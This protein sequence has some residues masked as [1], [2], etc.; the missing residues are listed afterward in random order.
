MKFSWWCVIQMGVIVIFCPPKND[1]GKVGASISISKGKRF[2]AHTR[3]FC[4]TRIASGWCKVL[5]ALYGFNLTVTWSGLFHKLFNRLVENPRKGTAKKDP[6]KGRPT[7]RS[8]LLRDIYPQFL[9]RCG[10]AHQTF[11]SFSEFLR[12][13]PYHGSR[14][15][16][17]V[18]EGCAHGGPLLRLGRGGKVLLVHPHGAILLDLC[19]RCL[20][21][22]LPQVFFDIRSN[23]L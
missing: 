5:K 3:F 19:Q 14:L 2:R 16:R 22:L 23:V 21:L 18:D 15:R 8:K 1:N 17:Y 10:T 7:T 13:A 12:F 6:Y 4:V 11:N 9:T 20:N